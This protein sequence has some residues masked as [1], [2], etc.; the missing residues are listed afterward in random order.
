MVSNKQVNKAR[1]ALTAVV[2]TTVADAG[3]QGLPN[4]PLLTQ[5]MG[6][7]VE[8]EEYMT[9]LEA[10]KRT[11]LIKESNHVLTIT[12]EGE[13]QAKRLDKALGSGD[14]QTKE[15]VLALGAATANGNNNDTKTKE[16]EVMKA[17]SEKSGKAAKSSKKAAKALIL[18]EITK[19]PSKFKLASK[20]DVGFVM[21]S[22]SESTAD[23]ETGEVTL[24]VVTPKG[25]SVVKLTSAKLAEQVI[26]KKPKKADKAKGEKPAKAK[27]PKKERGENQVAQM[28][29]LLVEGKSWEEILAAFTERFAAQYGEQPE[30]DFV[31]KRCKIFAWHARNENEQAKA[32]LE[33]HKT[34]AKAAAKKAKKKGKKA[35]A[36]KE[37]KADKE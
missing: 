35:K 4:G 3:A 17:K 28:T 11:D 31:A 5:L 2:L 26:A 30:A 14:A 16:T 6:A 22:P 1:V 15:A 9:V 27:K 18:E 21:I 23:T 37:E 25:E 7:G 33:K 10:L 19:F 32:T 12:K 8:T 20:E 36:T 29:R 24:A 34:D 13:L